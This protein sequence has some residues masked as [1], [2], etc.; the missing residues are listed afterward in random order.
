[1]TRDSEALPRFRAAWLALGW[2]M[3]GA[4]GVGSL[5][6][7]M[8]G[9]AGGLSDKLLHFGAY[10]ALAFVFAGAIE[11]RRWWRIALGLLALGTG[12]EIMQALLTESRSAE[13]LDATAN[14]LGVATGLISAALFPGGWCRQIE[15]AFARPA[16]RQ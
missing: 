8:P 5:W 3:V 13:W 9:L 11:R 16:E 12:I 14:A 7:S 15:L 4:V 10:S 1:V 6:P 2:L